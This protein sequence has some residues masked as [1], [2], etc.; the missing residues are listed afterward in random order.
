MK[1]VRSMYGI[2]SAILIAVLLCATGCTSS[3][4]PTSEMEAAGAALEAARNAEADVYEPEKYSTASESMR[5]AIAEVDTQNSRLPFL[6]DYEHAKTLL[7]TARLNAEE[8]VKTSEVTKQKVIEEAR[9]YLN[10]ISQTIDEATV[11]LGA[12]AVTEQDKLAFEELKTKL[13]GLQTAYQDA[14]A[15]YRDGNYVTARD[16]SKSILDLVQ[17]LNTQIKQEVEKRVAALPKPKG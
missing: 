12:E 13:N 11:T 16:K 9:D 5:T 8:A 2:C 17:V 3:Q 4:E 14:D 7:E 10:R 6:R 15:Q 1:R